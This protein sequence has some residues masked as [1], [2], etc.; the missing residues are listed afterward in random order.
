MMNSCLLVET[1]VISTTRLCVNITDKTEDF[2]TDQNAV[3]HYR[4]CCTD[5]SVCFW[6]YHSL[7]LPHGRVKAHSCNL[8]LFVSNSSSTTNYRVEKKKLFNA[9][10]TQT[11]RYGLHDGWIYYSFVELA[12]IS[13]SRVS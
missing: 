10:S 8:C 13:F 9:V 7:Q 3:F 11:E 6:G 1:V 12:C 5:F 4:R 2:S